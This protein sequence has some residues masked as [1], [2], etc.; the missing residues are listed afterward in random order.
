MQCAACRPLLSK[1]ADHETTP[2][3]ARL[4]EEHLG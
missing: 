2:A 4:V 3:E 1:Y